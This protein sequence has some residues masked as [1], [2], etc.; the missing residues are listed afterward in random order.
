MPT[1]LLFAN[2]GHLLGTGCNDG[3]RS[4]ILTNELN[5]GAGNPV[6]TSKNYGPPLPPIIAYDKSS[7]GTY[8]KTD[9]GVYYQDYYYDKSCYEANTVSNSYVYLNEFNGH[10]HDNMGFHYHMTTDSNSKCMAQ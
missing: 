10:D 3:K 1:L 6:T 8:V 7:S 2:F 4:C 5:Y 9:I